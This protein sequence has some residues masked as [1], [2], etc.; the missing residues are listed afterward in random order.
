MLQD[1][2]ITARIDLNWKGDVTGFLLYWKETLRK[3][4]DI[5]PKSEHY[6]WTMKKRLLRAAVNG[7]PHLAQVDKMDHDQISRGQSALTFEQ[8]FTILTSAASQV[9]FENSINK[10]PAQQRTV[11]YLDLTPEEFTELSGADGNIEIDVYK[12]Q[13]QGNKNGG[14]LKKTFVH[15]NSLYVPYNVW[16]QLTPRVQQVIKNARDGDQV[17]SPATAPKNDGDDGEDVLSR[18]EVQFHETHTPSSKVDLTPKEGET[19]NERDTRVLM[20]HIFKR[21]TMEPSDIRR[22]LAASQDRRIEEIRGE[23]GAETT[24]KKTV[25]IDGVVYTAS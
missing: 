16:E 8:Y 11:N 5:L 23:Q 1:K 6:P 3:L 9:D 2:L 12:S 19:L 13:Q 4:E 20:N 17:Q 22:V 18:R 14:D 25:T 21:Q 7:H 24:K 10:R 15:P